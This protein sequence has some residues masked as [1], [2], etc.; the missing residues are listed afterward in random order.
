MDLIVHK[1]DLM[2]VEQFLQLLK[3]TLRGH[4]IT[5]G[6]LHRLHEKR[7]VFTIISF[8]IDQGIIFRLE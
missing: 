7:P 6:G 2:A 8:R 5:S 1:Q 3:I 4:D